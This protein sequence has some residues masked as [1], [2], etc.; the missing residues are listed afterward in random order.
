MGGGAW[1]SLAIFGL[2]RPFCSSPLDR[3]GQLK[4]FHSDCSGKTWKER[5]CGPEGT[6]GLS[7]IST[8]RTAFFFFL[9]ALWVLG[10]ERLSVVSLSLSTAWSRLWYCNTLEAEAGG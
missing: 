10:Q 8:L 4:D 1:E 3:V 5:G 6:G 2:F 7:S 9:L